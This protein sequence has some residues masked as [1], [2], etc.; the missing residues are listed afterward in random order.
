MRA[1]RREPGARGRGRRT[2]RGAPGRDGGESSRAREGP[3]RPGLEK[4]LVAVAARW[5]RGR[6]GRGRRGG[7]LPIRGGDE[8]DPTDALAVRIAGCRVAREV[9]E[10]VSG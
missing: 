9:V 4:G 8:P 1:P 3:P 5:A 10:R 2:G 7:R 6:L